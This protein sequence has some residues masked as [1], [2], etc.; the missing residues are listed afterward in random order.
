MITA[1][2]APAMAQLPANVPLSST[3]QPRAMLKVPFV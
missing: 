3:L 2:P 1:L